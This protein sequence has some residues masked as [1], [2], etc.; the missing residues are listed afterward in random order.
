MTKRRRRILWVALIIA[1]S[2]ASFGFS[3]APAPIYQD[4]NPAD[5]GWIE[6]TIAAD[7]EMQGALTGS[8]HWLPSTVLLGVTQQPSDRIWHVHPETT[9]SG[10]IA[11]ATSPG[12]I[13]MN[14][15]QP[16]AWEVTAIV[17]PDCSTEVFLTAYMYPGVSTGCAPLV[18]CS[19]LSEPAAVIEGPIVNIPKGEMFGLVPWHF[20]GATGELIVIIQSMAIGGGCHFAHNLP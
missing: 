9:F 6:I 3:T 8:M 12:P 2:I 15:V 11:Y 4:E 5:I 20:S 16:L 17:Y 13:T 19:T 14:L 18:G 10:F 7:V 1:L